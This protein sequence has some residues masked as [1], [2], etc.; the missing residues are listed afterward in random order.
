MPRPTN[1]KRA[2]EAAGEIMADALDNINAIIAWSDTERDI[3]T[4]ALD[5]SRRARLAKLN[6]EV[7]GL[8]TNMLRLNMTIEAMRRG[9]Y[10]KR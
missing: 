4:N 6:G 5:L 7:A 1:E 10:V 3:A 9:E 8:A 2:A